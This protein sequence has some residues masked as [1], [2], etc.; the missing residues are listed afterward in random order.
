VTDIEGDHTVVEDAGIAFGDEL[1][2]ATPWLHNGKI[3]EMGLYEVPDTFGGMASFAESIFQTAIR[4]VSRN[5]KI[6]LNRGSCS[7]GPKASGL[8]I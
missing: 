7:D 1:E 8:F 4:L 6:L 5:D 3:A 2:F